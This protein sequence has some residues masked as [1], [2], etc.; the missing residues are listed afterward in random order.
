MCLG[1]IS[2]PRIPKLGISDLEDPFLGTLGPGI[3][4]PVADL[5]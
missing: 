2:S 5:T 3:A 1:S 4:P